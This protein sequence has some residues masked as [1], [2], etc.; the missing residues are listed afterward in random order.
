MLIDIH[1]HCQEPRHAKLVRPGGL[2]TPAEGELLAMLD[3]RGIDCAVVMCTVSPEFRTT[4]VIPEEVLRV[5]ARH[6]DRLIPFC[7]FDP[8]YVTN[9]T[10]ADFRPLL[11]AY[12]EMGCKGVGEYMP[13]IPLDDPLNMNFFAQVEEAGLPLTF[14]LAPKLG[15]FYGCV[16][17]PGLPRLERALQAF[18]KLVFLGHSQPFWAEIGTNVVENGVRPGYPKGP[19]A[20]G[21]VVEL[22][23]RYP[24]L[25]GDLSANSGYI[26]MT[27]DP[28]FGLCFMEEFQ[29]RLYFATDIAVTPQDTPIVFWFDGL[30]RERQISPE[31]W[32]KIAWKNAARLLRL[33]IP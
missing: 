16:D 23:R 17:D 3:A 21:R 6:A 14:H 30:K 27:R 32:E 5:C 26:A 19:V 13:N 8:R 2:P 22:M 31:A 24:N 4:L 1:T 11:A 28:A 9:N 29:D 10:Q 12:K 18:P 7:C 15:D 20:P 25:H 33:K